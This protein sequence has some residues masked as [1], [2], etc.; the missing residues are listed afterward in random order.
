MYAYKI[1]ICIGTRAPLTH[2]VSTVSWLEIET[3]ECAD[4]AVLH[5]KSFS[6]EPRLK[7]SGSSRVA[8]RLSE[9]LCCVAVCKSACATRTSATRYPLYITAWASDLLVEAGDGDQVKRAVAECVS[10]VSSFFRKRGTRF[11]VEVALGLGLGPRN[12]CST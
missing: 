1:T 6:P 4:A 11:M 3:S 8:F 12:L 9:I 2:F 5:P 7:E 10:D